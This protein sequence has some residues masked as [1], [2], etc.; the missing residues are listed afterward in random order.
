[1]Y[2]IKRTKPT[3][4]GEYLSSIYV[5]RTSKIYPLSWSYYHKYAIHFKNIEEG[6]ETIK[7]IGAVIDTKLA[8]QLIIVPMEEGRG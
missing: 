7:F 5:G 1:M 6:Q 8:E 2:I 4:K 3:E